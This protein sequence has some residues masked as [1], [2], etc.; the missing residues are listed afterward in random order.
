[1][2][3]VGRPQPAALTS[4][5]SRSFA[6]PHSH[7]ARSMWPP[8]LP[9]SPPSAPKRTAVPTRYIHQLPH[10]PQ[11]QPIP[12]SR[13]VSHTLTLHHI[14]RHSH[15][16][17]TPSSLH[18]PPPPPATLVRTPRLHTPA[19]FPRKPLKASLTCVC[20]YVCIFGSHRSFELFRR[21]RGERSGKLGI[22]MTSQWRHTH[23][24]TA[25][26]LPLASSNSLSLFAT[27]SARTLVPLSHRTHC[28]HTHMHHPITFCMYHR[29][30]I[31]PQRL[32]VIDRSFTTTVTCTLYI[33]SA[34]SKINMT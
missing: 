16:R 13:D 1:M 22:S 4:N 23:M 30:R 6:Q 27:A 10:L 9:P 26:S 8:Q 3:V 21:T 5:C 28:T 2:H 11:P 12:S 20:V 18:S 32:E 7:L 29:T 19:T 25:S 34:R 14:T 31:H 17:A 24:D 33:L 15:R